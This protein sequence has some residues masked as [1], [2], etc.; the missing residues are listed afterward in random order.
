LDKSGNILVCDC[1][2]WNEASKESNN[3]IQVFNADGKYQYEFGSTGQDAGQF[4]KPTRVV[5]DK[6]GRILVTDMENN[7]IQVFK[8]GGTFLNTICRRGKSDCFDAP[9]GIAVMQDGRIIITERE[10]NQIQIF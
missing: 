1:G 5:V 10:S 9:C 6:K 7:R 4:K 3:R 2:L 8:S